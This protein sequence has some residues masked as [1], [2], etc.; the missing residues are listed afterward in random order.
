METMTV[1]EALQVTVNL[2][3][4]ISVPRNLNAQ[5]GVPIDQAISNIQQCIGAIERNERKE[6]EDER[7][8]PAGEQPET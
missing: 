2:L 6:D 8:D 3:G 7:V 4:N 5:I 1:K